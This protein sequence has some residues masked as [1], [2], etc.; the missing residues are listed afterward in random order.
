MTYDWDAS[1]TAEQEKK[2]SQ[3]PRFPFFVLICIYAPILVKGTAKEGDF[4]LAGDLH[5]NRLA[6][7]TPDLYPHV[8]HPVSTRG[9]GSVK[10]I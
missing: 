10:L 4:T 8:I 9:L 1:V 2:E 5:K 7:G 6:L 3:G